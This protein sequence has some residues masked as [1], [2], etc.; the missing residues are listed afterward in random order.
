[1]SDIQQAYLH[2]PAL[3]IGTSLI[4]YTIRKVIGNGGFGI[5]YLA[6][7]EITDKQV[8]IK[9]NYPFKFSLRNIES[10]HVGP[11]SESH[12]DAYEWALTRFMDEAK[13]LSRLSHPNIVP[14][15][16]AF[17]ALGTAYYVMPQV[18]GTEL[19]KAAPAPDNITSEWLLPVLEKLLSALAYL[20]SEGIIHRDIKPSNILLRI[21]GE[22]ILIDFGTAR[23]LESSQTQTGI[24]TPGFMPFE[25]H[26]TS[27]NR[28]PW[29]DF[30]ALGATCYYLITGKVPPS[31]IDRKDVDKYLPLADIP[32]LAERFPAHVLKSIDKALFMNIEERW[33]SAQEWLDALKNK[34]EPPNPTQTHT[35]AQ[36]ELKRQG[37]NSR[38]YGNTLLSAARRGDAQLISLLIAAGANVN[39]TDKD[40]ETPLNLAAGKGH[41]ECVLTLLAAPGIDVNKVSN[42]GKTP[43]TKAAGNGHAEC[44]NL[45][46]AAPGINVNKEKQ[47]GEIPLFEAAINGRTKCLRLLL[48]APGIDVNIKNSNGSTPL[49]W[50]AEHGHVEYL[51]LLL[52]APG[53]DVN[54]V[55]Q[56]G[57]T[58]LLLASDKGH[59]ECVRLLLAAPGIDVNKVNQYSYTP[60]SRAAKNGHIECLKLLLTK[61]EI[62]VNKENR[63]GVT[64]LSWAA[65]KGHT[66]CVRA[67]LTAPGI[68]VNKGDTSGNSPLS[69][70][71]DKGHTE[72][73]EL[74]RASSITTLQQT[75]V[76]T[77]SSYSAARMRIEENLPAPIPSQPAPKSAK[78]RSKARL[79]LILLLTACACAGVYNSLPPDIQ[80][81]LRGIR[82][83]IYNHE[84]RNAVRNGDTKQIQ[85]LLNAGAN[86]I[87]DND[88][89][90]PLLSEAAKKGHTECVK[91]LL[92]VPGI[93][94][95]QTTSWSKATPLSEAARLGYTECVRLLLAAPGIDVNKA[96]DDSNTPLC[97]AAKEG[98]T[99]CVRLL[100]AAPEIDVNQAN[101]NGE[102]PL[103]WAASN[104]HADCVRAL[105]NAPKID[106]S[107][108]PPLCLAAMT[109]NQAKIYQLLADGANPNRP[110]SILGNTPLNYA[111][112]N[113]YTDCVRA[114]LTAPR[115]NV[116]SQNKDNRT[117]LF[118]AASRGYINCVRALLAVPGIDVNK[119][120]SYN[121][122][123]LFKAASRGYINC[124]RA[125]LTVPGI[126]VNQTA[127]WS[128]TTPLSEAASCG[129]TECVRL[130][131]AAPGI[132]V[133]KV[134][135]F[136]STPLR[137]A[138]LYNHTECANLIRAA[139]G[140]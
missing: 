131:L 126:D 16:N 49:S 4:N 120:D 8:V 88:F 106:V 44:L 99:E 112:R 93:D 114:L 122:T 109:N 118:E 90:I 100:L 12:K 54:K 79:F 57:S 78:K 7:E 127:R 60:L 38:K 136:N 74:I 89:D 76:N 36:E 21:D 87:T 72:C 64:P 139:G 35:L 33:Q 48:A 32:S 6:Q 132:D 15:R 37:I 50:A 92:T 70:A 45:L 10:L 18:E 55:N 65:Y 91:I 83:Y 71:A 101:Q 140:K 110:D 98:H 137:A 104:C 67:L 94:V 138:E 95:N 86:A 42:N 63:N 25:Q 125:L 103:S 34:P 20:H 111:V 47:N 29:T 128:K 105:L 130:L 117:P 11:R 3:P 2:P 62:D 17:E 24:G 97:L 53:I 66:D 121:E 41:A 85:L 96:D 113:G 124:V 68:N 46:L 134:D 31:S 30:Y 43:L 115:I 13:I 81:S 129:Y 52:A 22:P 107:A 133:N 119:A 23:V 73:A 84:L 40:G 28:G 51:R 116:N 14:I 135:S 108:Y 58:P 82:P 61:P 27:G 19:H 5:T 26:S 39:K 1:M 80:L 75:E 56:I 77:V 9:E 123:P 102:T 69:L 59:T